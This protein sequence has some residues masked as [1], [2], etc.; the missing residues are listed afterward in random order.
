REAAEAAGAEAAALKKDAAAARGEATRREKALPALPE[1]EALDALRALR[2]EL[3]VAEAKLDVG[4]SVALRRQ[5]AVT[6][7]AHVDE[8]PVEVPEGRAVDLEARREVRVSI[9]LPTGEP[10]A[11]LVVRGGGAD[12]RR[13][14]EALRA[15]WEAEG[16]PSL[17]AAG[18]E[19]LE[20]LTAA[21]RDAEK[22][23]AAI[24]RRREEA[25]RLAE[26]AEAAARRAEA[27]EG[28]RRREAELERALEGVDREALAA[29]L[30]GVEAA[31]A[32]FDRRREAEAAREAAEAREKE[33]AA[34]LA[35]RA[36][37]AAVAERERELAE[38]T[39]AERGGSAGAGGADV[40]AARE[41]LARLEEERSRLEASAGAALAEATREAEAAKAARGEAEAAL[42]AAREAL[43][44]VREALGRAETK[45]EMLAE[46][47]GKEARAKLEAERDA[48]REA[49]EAVEAPEAEVEEAELEAAEAEA[50]AAEEALR[51]AE[52][53]LDK[54]EGL[55]EGTGGAVAQE[56]FEEA[57]EAFERATAKEEEVE[58]E[59]GAWRLLTEALR[60]AENAEGAH[61]G[62]A[63]GSKVAPRFEELLAAAGA[64]R[65]YGAL[66]L[67]AHL[68]A[69]GIEAHGELRETEA[70]S[71]GTREQL[72]T[73]IRLS[74]AEALGAPLVLDDHLTHT[75][76]ARTAWFRDV[77]RAAAHDTQVLVLTCHPRAYLEEGDLPGE[78]EA[79][80]DRA[81]GLVRALDAERIIE[82]G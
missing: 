71:V 3:E 80:R 12:A 31:E 77:L 57:Q 54:H 43:G 44:E 81:A 49:L 75:D 78:G 52:R 33:A 26:K 19:D 24:A 25:D 15:R 8:E 65:P 35:E 39:L 9:A 17:E 38:A 18:L 32:L 74:V 63:L 50:T 30:E 66:T 51:T 61:L 60:E 22:E 42:G 41:A 2:R 47:L 27:L 45:Q 70:L 53:A 7:D 59:Y 69:E 16:A 46:R 5:P 40:P 11:D 4:L 21:V 1:A 13:E 58:V 79:A 62:E 72:A 68:G 20:A 34:T 82:A 55:L 14:A 76:P 23:R 28:L 6:V 73:L 56:R 67:D 10:M 48:A 29:E 37:A 36:Q 64:E